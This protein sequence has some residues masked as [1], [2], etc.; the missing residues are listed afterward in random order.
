MSYREPARI[1]NLATVLRYYAAIIESGAIDPPPEHL[2]TPQ[3]TVG[4]FRRLGMELDLEA[5]ARLADI[6]D[7][8]GALAGDLPAR[9]SPPNCA[10]PAPRPADYS[11]ERVMA[12]RQAAQHP[13]G[14]ATDDGEGGGIGSRLAPGMPPRPRRRR[15]PQ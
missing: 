7:A 5:A 12:R 1:S 4:E 13:E 2:L 6:Q 3:E 10:Q 8:D 11:A 14:A 9:Q 15:G